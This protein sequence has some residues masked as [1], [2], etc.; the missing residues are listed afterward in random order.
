[1][2]EGLLRDIKQKL[3]FDS[4][5]DDEPQVKMEK[6]RKI[7]MIVDNPADKI[8]RRKASD[9]FELNQQAQARKR[10][11]T[12]KKE[13]ETTKGNFIDL[14]ESK[15]KDLAMDLGLIDDSLP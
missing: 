11:N 5:G 7:Q 4:D 14:I 9:D 10:T 12:F 2:V 8:Q 3:S 13:R 6:N 1:M 15:T